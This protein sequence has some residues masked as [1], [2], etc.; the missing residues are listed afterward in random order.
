MRHIRGIGRPPRHEL[1]R[2]AD[3]RVPFFIAPL[4]QTHLFVAPPRWAHDLSPRRPAGLPAAPPSSSPRQ[5]TPPP[6][7]PAPRRAGIAGT[8][9]RFLLLSPAPAPAAPRRALSSPAS[10]PAPHRRRAVFC[11]DLPPPPPPKRFSVWGVCHSH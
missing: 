9:Q 10:S 7:L 11:A 2:R 1:C 3:F 5:P 4:A 6:R 8:A